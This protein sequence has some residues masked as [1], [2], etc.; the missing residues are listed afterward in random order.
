MLF[1][2][3]RVRPARLWEALWPG[4]PID[5]ILPDLARPESSDWTIAAAWLLALIACV[6]LARRAQAKAPA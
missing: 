2:N 6:F 1:I 3:R 4:G 5:G